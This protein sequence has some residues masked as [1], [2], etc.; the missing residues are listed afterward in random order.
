MLFPTI[1]FAIFFAVVLPLSWILLPNPT[2]WKVFILLA[3][4]FFL[5]YPSPMVLGVIPLFVA[6]L[7]GSSVANWVFGGMVAA[8]TSDRARRIFLA[9]AIIANLGLLG[10]FKY[11]NFF[12]TQV[13]DVLHS[14]GLDPGIHTMSIVLPIAISFFTFQS[15]SYVIDIYRRDLE[16]VKLLEF[17]VYIA[18]FPHLIAGPIVRASEFVPQLRA[19]HDPRSVDAT[20][21]FMLIVGGLIKKLVIADFLGRAIVK[22]VFPNPEQFGAITLIIAVY[23]YAVQ[24]YCDFSGYTDI[25]IGL[26]L[27]LGFRFPQNFDRPYAAENIQDFWRRWHMTLSRWLRDYLYIPLGGNRRAFIPGRGWIDLKQPTA[28]ALAPSV[29]DEI[30]VLPPKPK[31]DPKWFVYGNLMIVMV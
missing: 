20:R 11:Y 21:A 16:P 24:I 5:A 18:F 26:A 2:R 17:M 31:L 19:K 6:L 29:D 7:L 22:E 15:M 10:Y 9:V 28:V 3:S 23:A 13:R 8:A 25:A 12:L 30:A 14:V 4:Y 27:L 1:T